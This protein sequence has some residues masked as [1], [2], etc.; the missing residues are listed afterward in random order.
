MATRRFAGL[1]VLPRLASG[2]GFRPARVARF[3]DGIGCYL[4]AAAM[5]GSQGSGEFFFS[6]HSGLKL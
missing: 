3:R 1:L 4:G 6:V 2:E 5:Q